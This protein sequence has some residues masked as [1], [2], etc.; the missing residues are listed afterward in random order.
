[1]GWGVA[2]GAIVPGVIPM[3]F[4]RLPFNRGIAVP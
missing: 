4:Y 3:S 2:A 1:M